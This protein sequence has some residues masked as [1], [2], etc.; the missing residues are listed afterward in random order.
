[1]DCGETLMELE[2]FAT[3][4]ENI[5]GNSLE[6][7]EELKEFLDEDGYMIYV[8][9][10]SKAVFTYKEKKDWEEARRTGRQL[11]WKSEGEKEKEV[12]QKEKRRDRLKDLLELL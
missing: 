12:N 8:H 9:R 1:M 4:Q 6:N 10:R 3:A 11:S 5:R 7:E 2:S